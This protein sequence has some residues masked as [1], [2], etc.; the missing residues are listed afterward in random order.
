MHEH[1]RNAEREER[2]RSSHRERSGESSLRE[3]QPA[4]RSFQLY[5]VHRAA[6]E[7][8]PDSFHLYGIGGH[9]D[10]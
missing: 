8:K 2:D 1:R 3:D 5:G 6:E 10:D 4:R 9:Q 7:H